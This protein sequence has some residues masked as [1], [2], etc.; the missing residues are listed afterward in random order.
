MGEHW[1]ITLYIL[2]VRDYNWMPARSISYFLPEVQS[3]RIT[4]FNRFAHVVLPHPL[5]R[6]VTPPYCL[7]LWVCFCWFCLLLLVLHS[8]YEGNHTALV[9]IRS[10]STTLS[11]STHAVANDSISSLYGWVAF[12]CIHATSSSSIHLTMDT[13]VASVS[14]PVG[15]AESC[16]SSILSLLSNFHTVLQSGCTNLHSVG[17]VLNHLRYQVLLAG[18]VC[19]KQK[20]LC[21][22]RANFTRF[23]ASQGWER[24]LFILSC[25]PG[26]SALSPGCHSDS[27]HT[28]GSA[29]SHSRAGRAEHLCHIFSCPSCGM[30]PFQGMGS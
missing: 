24:A 9:L 10:L 15:N 30:P 20:W 2:S 3:P 25:S 13:E 14:V 18:K 4:A 22:L 26:P 19:C 29:D 17:Y 23:P 8:M 1:L 28:L 11:R 16:G 6:L 27:A 12:R 7:Y 5:S 21:I